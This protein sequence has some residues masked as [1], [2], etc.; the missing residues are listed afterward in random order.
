MSNVEKLEQFLKTSQYGTMQHYSLKENLE[1]LDCACLKLGYLNDEIN[2]LKLALKGDDDRN[3]K[4]SHLDIIKKVVAI[5]DDVK[6][7]TK[8]ELLLI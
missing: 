6:A 8:D 1:D 3:A 7:K 4:Q 2:D 5:L